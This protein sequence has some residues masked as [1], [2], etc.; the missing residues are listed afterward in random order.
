MIP[1]TWTLQKSSNP[2]GAT[3]GRV[4]PDVEINDAASGRIIQ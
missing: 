1:R 2:L 3:T 4:P